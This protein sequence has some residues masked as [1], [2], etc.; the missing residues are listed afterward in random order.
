M[1]IGE[2]IVGPGLR[3]RQHVGSQEPEILRGSTY[4]ETCRQRPGG[5]PRPGV[6]VSTVL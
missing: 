3:E 5:A 6:A 4:V 2:L 1:G